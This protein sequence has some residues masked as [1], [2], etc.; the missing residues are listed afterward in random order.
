MR[1]QTLATIAVAFAACSSKPV[2]PYWRIEVE[3]ADE[4]VLVAQLNR[5]HAE[6][7][8]WP[9]VVIWKGRLTPEA[10]HLANYTEADA[11]N[12]LGRTGNAVL[13]HELTEFGE[14][15]GDIDGILTPWCATH[16]LPFCIEISQA[17]WML[18]PK[19]QF[20]RAWTA[21]EQDPV[22]RQVLHP[23]RPR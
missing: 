18:L 20:E 2:A 12:W 14:V 6:R 1:A 7:G 3:A 13:F 23:Y 8:A 10:C 21:A 9:D 5:V 16:D 22:V 4:K 17:T 15:W 11:T 19:S